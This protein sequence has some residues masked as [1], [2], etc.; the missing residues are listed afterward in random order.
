[1][2]SAKELEHYERVR[3]TFDS[4]G[5]SHKDTTQSSANPP[6]TQENTLPSRPKSKDRT[7][8]KGKGKGKAPARDW[9]DFEADDEP[10]DD[11]DESAGTNRATSNGHKSLNGWAKGKAVSRNLGSSGFGDPSEND[12]EELYG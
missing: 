12:E 3:K 2:D 9:A 5:E 6:V 4:S 1:M 7:A 8:S 11:E 10:G